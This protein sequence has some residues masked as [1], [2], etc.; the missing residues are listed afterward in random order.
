MPQSRGARNLFSRQTH[1][2][3]PLDC[4]VKHGAAT[5]IIVSLD[6]EEATKRQQRVRNIQPVLNFSRDSERLLI[7]LFGLIQFSPLLVD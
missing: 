5:G 7:V 2:F 6:G 4:F 1:A 3:V